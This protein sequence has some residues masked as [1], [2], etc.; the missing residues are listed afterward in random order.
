MIPLAL[1]APAL[2]AAGFIG[3]WNTNVTAGRSLLDEGAA[4]LL[5]GNPSLAGEPL[6]MEVALG[7]IHTDDKGWVF[8]RIRRVRQTGGSFSA[9]FRVVTETGV[10]WVLNRG[11][12][13]PDEFGRMHGQGAYID[14][15]NTH[16]DVFMP[17]ASIT[18]DIE[19][20]LIAAADHCVEVHTT[21][22]RGDYPDLRHL[23]EMLLV[24]IGRTLALRRS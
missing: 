13:V 16:S 1:T 9:E 18:Q 3:I 24:G 7:R 11:T 19:D 17:A 12:L 22:K 21:L 14:T 10:R 23:S 4:A 5:A 15:T 2:K 8:D 20:P 6:P